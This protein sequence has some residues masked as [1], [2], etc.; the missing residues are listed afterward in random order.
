MSRAKI[1]QDATVVA[2]L[3]FT[4][5]SGLKPWRDSFGGWFSALDPKEK[6]FGRLGGQGPFLVPGHAVATQ[7]PARP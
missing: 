6:V 5:S 2:Y 1:S 4:L 7:N 3:G